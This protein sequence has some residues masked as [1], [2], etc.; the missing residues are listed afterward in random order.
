MENAIMPNENN[1]K[2]GPR[3]E[4]HSC[5]CGYPEKNCKNCKETTVQKKLFIGVALKKLLLQK[6][7]VVIADT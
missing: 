2:F 3:P 6:Q 5:S 1:R 4:E 7:N